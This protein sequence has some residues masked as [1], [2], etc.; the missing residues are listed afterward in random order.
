MND[1]YDIKGNEL[2][3]FLSED[4]FLFLSSVII[5]WL[6]IY[7]IYLNRDKFIN[8]QEFEILKVKRGP[9]LN[10]I[11]NLKITDWDFYEILSFTVRL[12]ICRRWIIKDATNKT[13]KEI[14]YFFNKNKNYFYSILNLKKENIQI[15]K[16]FL[17]K[18]AKY[19]FEEVWAWDD[20]KTHLK[21]IA[22]EIIN[23]F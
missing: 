1:I 10:K 17:E 6:I 22:R 3:S 11:K 19:Q 16:E 21:K 8:N 20:D 23:K 4:F 18:I 14:F 13:N 9:F 5:W 12:Y 2:I 15:F 7:V